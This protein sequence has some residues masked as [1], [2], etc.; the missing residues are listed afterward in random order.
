[1]RS[2]GEKVCGIDIYTLQVSALLGE[3][4]VKHASLPC[5]WILPLDEKFRIESRD[6][7][8]KL[9]LEL[10]SVSSFERVKKKCDR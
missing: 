8:S 7:F 2:L 1:M 9:S 10:R 6:S 4:R 5:L 3:Q